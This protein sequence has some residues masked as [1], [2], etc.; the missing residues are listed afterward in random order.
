MSESVKIVIRIS[1]SEEGLSWHWRGITCPHA[2]IRLELP[3][4]VTCCN[5]RRWIG[6]VFCIL[7]FH[8]P[9]LRVGTLDSILALIDDLKRSEIICSLT[10]LLYPRLHSETQCKVC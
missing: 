1:I 4:V 2:P 6:E 9:D 8:I 5:G 7:Q 3:V 10:A